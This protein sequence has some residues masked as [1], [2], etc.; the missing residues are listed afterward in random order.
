MGSTTKST[1]GQKRDVEMPGKEIRREKM[2]VEYVHGEVMP[3]TAQIPA[4]TSELLRREIWVSDD[5]LK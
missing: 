5:H 3:S 2:Q 1:E 4:S